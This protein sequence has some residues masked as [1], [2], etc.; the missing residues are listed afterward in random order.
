MAFLYLLL[1]ADHIQEHIRSLV[2]HLDM[3]LPLD[4]LRRALDT[5]SVD[6]PCKYSPSLSSPVS[7]LPTRCLSDFLTSLLDAGRVGLASYLTLFTYPFASDGGP[8]R[9]TLSLFILLANHASLFILLIYLF[10]NTQHHS[11]RTTE[12]TRRPRQRHLHTIVSSV[13]YLPVG[14][15]PN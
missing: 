15:I 12:P 2:Y 1:P 3:G 10:I 7:F 8:R 11:L 5:S 9:L 4:A 14:S 6:V 13:P